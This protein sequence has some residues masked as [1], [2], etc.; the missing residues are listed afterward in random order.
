MFRIHIIIRESLTDMMGNAEA[1]EV[2]EE[3]KNATTT[4]R[5]NWEH[6]GQAAQG[7]QGGVRQ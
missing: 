2:E 1:V 4:A 5:S 3:A 6:C 7:R